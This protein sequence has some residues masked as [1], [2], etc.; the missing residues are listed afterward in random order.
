MASVVVMPRVGISVESCIIGTWEKVPGDKVFVGEVLFD[1][2]TD[3]TS[4][5]CVS[6]SEGTL[7]E[8]FFESGDE[9]PCLVAVCAIGELGEDVSELRPAEAGGAMQV[10]EDIAADAAKCSLQKHEDSTTVTSDDTCGAAEVVAWKGSAVTPKAQNLANKLGI[11]VGLA[12]PTGPRGRVI[13]QDIS[14]LAKSQRMGT[15]FGGR[16]FDDSA[17]P[18]QTAVSAEVVSDTELMGEYVDERFTTIRKVIASMMIKSLTEIAQL[19]HHHSFDATNLIEFHKSC[20]ARSEAFEGSEITLNDIILYAASRVLTEHP[21]LNAHLVH[22]DI[23]RR[24][25]GVHLGMA[26]DTPRGL[27]VPTIF[28]ADKMTLK[29]ISLKTKE[30]ATMCRN[31]SINPDL[32][33]GATFTVSNLGALGV[34]FFTPIINPP[35]VANL[36][37][38][39]I[40]EKVRS[41]K[42]GIETYQSMGIS[43]TYDHRAIDGAPA[44]RFVRDLCVNLTQLEPL[45][46]L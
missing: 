14:T 22:G 23:L 33:Q 31:N 35:Q 43:L 11:D 26:V 27:M 17:A 42:N 30:L 9:V 24:Y 8:C 12:I 41:G 40:V 25:S 19:T 2:E 32:L 29:E 36:G 20:K 15:G 4:F 46:A 3:K 10:R 39:G 18:K 38:C 6:T 45:P 1:Y 16:A 28:N 7:L 44:S 34:E 37:V 5:E 21:N 13:E